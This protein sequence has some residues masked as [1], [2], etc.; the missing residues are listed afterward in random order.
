MRQRNGLAELTARLIGRLKCAFEFRRKMLFIACFPKSGS[1]YFMELLC[2]VTGFQRIHL[3]Y[4]YERSSQNIYFPSLV[5]QCHRNGVVQQHIRAT[6]AHIELMNNYRIIP[7][8]HV[9]NIFDVVISLVEYFD[10]VTNPKMFICY[11]NE[12]YA[13]MSRKE[14]IDFIIEF[15][16][17]WYFHFYVSWWDSMKKNLI[18]V[19]WTSY[20]EML[21]EPETMLNRVLEFSRVEQKVKVEEAIHR[22]MYKRKKIR[23]NKGV[24][25]RGMVELT[26]GQQD[27]IRKYADYYPWVDFSP[28]GIEK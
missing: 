15:A 1:T 7:I 16:V 17:P 14:K 20:E 13:E 27:K 4:S 21:S 18:N 5:D 8:I 6:H 25:G 26:M 10:S 24:Q 23:F 19:I 3:V 9:R 22:V 2:E 28:I 12:K 11:T